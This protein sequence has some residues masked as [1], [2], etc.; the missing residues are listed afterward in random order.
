M[1]LLIIF[2]L[3]MLSVFTT[4]I[5]F[6][7]VYSINTRR[8]KANNQFKGE[9][10]NSQVLTLENIE[11]IEIIGF[12]EDIY[13]VESDS[14]E[15]IL[16]EYK[17][18]RANHSELATT[19]VKENT[20]FITGNPSPIQNTKK[21]YRREELW[22]PSS[23]HGKLS[24]T[25][26][27]GNIHG[28]MNLMLKNINLSSESGDITL[29][30]V[31]AEEIR[32]STQSGLI[33]VER[34]EGKRIFQSTSGYIKVSSGG[35]DSVVSTTSGGITLTNTTGQLDVKSGSGGLLITAKKGWGNINTNSGR[36]D[37]TLFE[38]QEPF[39]INTV[40]GDILLQITDNISCDFRAACEHGNI[41]TFFDEQVIQ[42]EN[43]RVVTGS[44]GD[45][46]TCMILLTSVS[47]DILVDRY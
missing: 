5:F 20:L 40:S 8:Y 35:G 28:K 12:L 32:V 34:A 44:L 39:T 42:S 4:S 27:G 3:M 2:S 33:S 13:L 1:K 15:L 16:K 7:I 47:G 31:T 30:S 37:V 6:I 41:N 25:V 23:Y 45:A 11:A 43:G 22:I 38:G 10:V 24:I 21:Q 26:T 9:L 18:R 36:V 14:D 17:A 29:Q 19:E 46:P